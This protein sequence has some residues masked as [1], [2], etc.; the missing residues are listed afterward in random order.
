MSL[1]GEKVPRPRNAC[2]YVRQVRTGVPP[3]PGPASVARCDPCWPPAR[4]SPERPGH[5]IP[6]ISAPEQCS[7]RLCIPWVK[8]SL[9]PAPSRTPLQKHVYF[10]RNLIPGVPT[11][12]HLHQLPWHFWRDMRSRGSLRGLG[13]AWSPFSS[14]DLKQK[15]RKSRFVF[16]TILTKSCLQIGLDWIFFSH[17]FFCHIVLLPCLTEAAVSPQGEQRSWVLN[18]SYLS[19]P[20]SRF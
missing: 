15:K 18:G 20:C 17:R 19:A 16:R 3:R 6:A 13:S 2:A 12:S 4:G 5:L 9:P 10:S 7:Y 14:R 8:S 11:P 1:W